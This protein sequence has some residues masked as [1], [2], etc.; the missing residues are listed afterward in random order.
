L[1]LELIA[2]DWVELADFFLFDVKG[3]FTDLADVLL[4]LLESQLKGCRVLDLTLHKLGQRLLVQIGPVGTPV[5]V[6]GRPK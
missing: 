4:M 5:Y 2:K 3:R 6:F 1:P